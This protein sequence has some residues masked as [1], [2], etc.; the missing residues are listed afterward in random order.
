MFG[1][2]NRLTL[3]TLIVESLR[4]GAAARAL[5][6]SGRMT[7]VEQFSNVFSPCTHHVKPVACDVSQRARVLDH[8]EGAEGAGKGA[9][10]LFGKL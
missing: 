2:R 6:A 1:V 4:T 9:G 8:P 5:D 3:E 7:V 10:H